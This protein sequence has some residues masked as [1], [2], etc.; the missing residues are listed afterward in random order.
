MALVS[1]NP[2]HLDRVWTVLLNANLHMGMHISSGVYSFA[3]FLEPLVDWGEPLEFR[4]S[5]LRGGLSQ[6][7]ADS[8]AM[9]GLFVPC[10]S[11][12]SLF[13]ICSLLLSNCS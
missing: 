2:G 4:A 6:F 13:T 1:V 7:P 12:Y 5:S 11:L 8:D 3:P 9:L 10:S